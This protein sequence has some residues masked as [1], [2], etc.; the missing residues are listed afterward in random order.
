M[1]LS[2][3]LQNV[4]WLSRIGSD[5]YETHKPEPTPRPGGGTWTTLGPNSVPWI[6]QVSHLVAQGFHWLSRSYKNRP[7]CRVCATAT[8][9][10]DSPART[11]ARTRAV[12]RSPA[13]TRSGRFRKDAAASDGVIG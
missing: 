6:V 3:G 2:P 12:A 10:C 13:R 8:R 1:E 5:L 7:A 11:D 4:A 9:H